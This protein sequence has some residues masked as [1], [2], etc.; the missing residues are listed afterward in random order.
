MNIHSDPSIRFLLAG[1]FVLAGCGSGDEP[2][3]GYDAT[4]TSEAS[5]AFDMPPIETRADSIA[6]SIMEA[7]GG[8]DA[9]RRIRYV[10]FDFGFEGADGKRVAR[11]HLW[12]RFRNR[13]RVEWQTGSD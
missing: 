3:A 8:V 13:Y 2:G 5:V 4:A 12:D 11:R 7:H 6:L 1:L 9:W 10:R